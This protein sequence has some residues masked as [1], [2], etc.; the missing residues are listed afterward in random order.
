[1]AWIVD[2]VLPRRCVS[3]AAAGHAFCA[4]CR[5]ALRA[6]SPPQCARC[7]AP[8][9][10]PVERC[11]ECAGR[12][13]AFA[14]ARSA[15][16]YAGP[17]KPFL[18]GWKERGLRQ[19]GT[20]AGEL[21]AERLTPVAADVVTCVPADRVRQLERSRHPA[22]MLARELARRW[23]LPYAALLGRARAAQRQAGLAYVGR[24]ANVQ[25][26]FEAREG[27]PSRVLLVDDVYTTGATASAGA[28]ALRRAGAT[29]VEIVTF[30]RAVR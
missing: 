25:G 15:F 18:R 29:R 2:L 8:T 24:R 22:E 5:G 23:G 20:L 6:L 28:S 14:S 1:V 3:C 9:A 17:A 26:A 12:R 4:Q 11:R 16:A 30:A 19:L 27:V 7:G 13:L 21:V 10:W